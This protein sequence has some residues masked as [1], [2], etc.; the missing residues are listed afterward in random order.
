M[1]TPTQVLRPWR[2][3]VR[4]AFQFIVA[5][6]VLLPFIVDATGLEPEVYPWLGGILAV[7]AGVTRVMALP[8]VEAFLAQFLPWLAADPVKRGQ[9]GYIGP[10][11]GRV[12]VAVAV[13][14]LA[15]AVLVW[16]L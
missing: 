9:G 6:F 3:T 7:A 12:L 11:V 4:T 1:T 8:Q 5:F 15:F 14:L 13:V 2:A 10:E 16:L